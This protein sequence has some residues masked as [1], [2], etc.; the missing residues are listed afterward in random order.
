VDLITTLHEETERQSYSPDR[1]SGMGL[2]WRRMNGIDCQRLSPNAF[3][4]KDETKGKFIES[5]RSF[6]SHP[7]QFRCEMLLSHETP[8][9]VRV[10]DASDPRKLSI[11]LARI[12]RMSDVNLF[13]QFVVADTLSTSVSE[14]RQM[15]EFERENLSLEFE[16]ILLKM[17]FSEDPERLLRFT[18]SKV[19]SES[20][21]FETIRSLAPSQETQFRALS[22]LSLEQRCAPLVSQEDLPCFL[23]PIQPTFAMG[24]LDRAQSADDLFGGDTSVLLRWENVYYRKKSCHKMLR[25]PARILWYVSGKEGA[26]VGV[27]HLDAVE[28]DAP[29]LLFRKYQKFGILEWEDVFEFCGKDITKEIMALRFSRTFMFRHRVMLE[30]LRSVLQS[31]SIGESLQSPS[32]IPHATFTKLFQLGY[33]NY[34]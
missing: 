32:S 10:I 30:E 8:I 5:V 26:I 22:S 7:E 6:L 12:D 3:C 31:D 25:A 1:V 27:S 19:M 2:V 13:G 11:P 24:L 15:V 17:G 28:I 33:P 16:P 29:K 14:G 23:V 18:L 21:V 34:L 9:A 20:S 4:R